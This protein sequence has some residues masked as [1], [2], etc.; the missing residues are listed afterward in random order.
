MS[1]H[2][3]L[4]VLFLLALLVAGVLLIPRTAHAQSTQVNCS[5]NTSNVNFGSVDPSQ[6]TDTT[7][8][9][10]ISFTCTS[11]TFFPIK[12]TACLNI[13]AG[14]GGQTAMLRQM[15]GTTSQKLD[16]QLYKD[17][18]HS[19]IWGSTLAS[20][21]ST[22]KQVQFTLNGY[23]TYTSPVY[24]IYGLVPGNQANVSTGAY[25]SIFSGAQASLTGNGNFSFFGGFPTSCGSTQYASASFTSSATVQPTCTVT[26]TDLNFGSVAGLL[27]SGNH[28]GTSTI[29]TKCVNGTAYKIGLD[30]GQNA[31]GNS[32]YMQG[33]GG[34]LIQYELYRDST[35][36]QRWGNT[37]GT[38]TVNKTGNGGS[39]NTTV[40]GR[41]PVQ[42]TPTPGAY[43]DT[44]T[45]DVTY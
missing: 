26:A 12:A 11:N 2:H 6:S 45:V 10:S 15:S 17:A 30:N 1:R 21:G 34:A 36:S 28:D 23:G 25:Q 38:D 18:A 3:L 32:R 41:V 9:A 35:R 42:T 29:S 16:F 5:M 19:R 37:P 14:S 39:Q 31:T 8:S 24:T 44:I 4:R 40:Y 13:G 27:S 7:A 43:S 33:P 20:N 22:A